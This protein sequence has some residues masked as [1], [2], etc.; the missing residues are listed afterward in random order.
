M[1]A[2]SKLLSSSLL[3]SLAVALL[4]QPALAQETDATGAVSVE[5]FVVTGTRLRLQDFVSPNPVS[6]VTSDTIERSGITNVTDLMKDYPAL[7]GSSDSQT[8]ADAGQ[9]SSVGLNLLNL[10]N[11]GV[12]RTLVLVDGRRHVAG[13]PGSAAVDTNSIPVGLIER[14]EVLTGGASAIYGADGVSG[15]VNFIT[16]R[17]FNGLDMR[18]QYGWSDGGGGENTFISV[19]GGRNFMDDRLNVTGAIE[20]SNTDPLNPEDRSFSR[21]GYREVLVDNPARFNQSDPNFDPSIWGTTDRV[22]ARNVRYI[23]SAVGGGVYTNLDATS[24]SG[25]SFY[26]DGTPWR[27]GIYAGG[28]TMIGGSGSQLDLFQT[29][30]TPGIPRIQSCSRHRWSSARLSLLGLLDERDHRHLEHRRPME[31]L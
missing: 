11:L 14:V 13:T 18:A 1:T 27:D 2:K 5:E 24:R 31:G 23:D 28:F 17:N 7:V 20:Y 22:F 15:V 26:G 25:I 19:V 9:R 10:R 21:P 30:L 6:S 16:K 8:F 12:D 4:A 3:S 29:E